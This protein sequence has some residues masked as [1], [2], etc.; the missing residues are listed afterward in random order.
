MFENKRAFNSTY[1]AIETSTLDSL[2]IAKG[3]FDVPMM[4][5]V[6]ASY[7]WDSRLTVAFDF[8]RQCMASATYNGMEGRFY[9]LRNRNRYAIGAEYRHNPMGRNYAER[10]LWRAGLN[11]Q[12]FIFVQFFADVQEN[13]A[14]HQVQPQMIGF[15]NEFHPRFGVQGND[16][17]VIQA[18]GSKA[19]LPCLH[20]LAA[21]EADVFEHETGLSFR[22]EDLHIALIAQQPHGS[23][24]VAFSKGRSAEGQRKNQDK[25]DHGFRRSETFPVHFIS[26]LLLIQA[27]PGSVS[28]A[29]G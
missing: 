25:N 3:G 28:G 27:E 18:D 17:A 14:F 2:Y 9:D 6:G 1:I 7:N 4:Y 19:F 13:P 15:F 22:I 8:E 12:A 10:M 11:V 26:F 16:L 20:N 5:G 29:P 24:V 21:G 23:G